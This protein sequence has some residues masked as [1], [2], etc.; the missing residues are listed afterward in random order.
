MIKSKIV[1]QNREAKRL[2]I[3]QT[4]I[5]ADR[6]RCFLIPIESQKCT[7][8]TDLQKSLINAASQFLAK[9]IE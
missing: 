3:D 2:R 5:D 8:C 7:E 6:N 4:I 9:Q 1:F